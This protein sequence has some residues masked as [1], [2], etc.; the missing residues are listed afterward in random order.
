MIASNCLFI[1]Q[2]FHRDTWWKL[3]LSG[4]TCTLTVNKMVPP[5]MYQRRWCNILAFI[6]TNMIALGAHSFRM[7]ANL[8]CLTYVRDWWGVIGPVIHG[9]S[10]S[11]ATRSRSDHDTSVYFTPRQQSTLRVKAQGTSCIGGFSQTDGWRKLELEIPKSRG[12][13]CI[14]ASS[15][16]RVKMVTKI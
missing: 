13:S 14:R 5:S 16:I 3:W 2:N 12:A 6:E 4:H 10:K 9:E 7:G 15:Y 1:Q 11:Q 8:I